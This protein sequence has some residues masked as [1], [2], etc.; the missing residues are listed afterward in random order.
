MLS[1]LASTQSSLKKSSSS[2]AIVQTDLLAEAAT[3]AI[4]DDIRQEMLAGA[5]GTAVPSTNQPMSVGRPWSM[6][7]GRVLS[8][9][10]NAT[11]TNF[12][13]LVKQSLS[14]KAFYPGL[15]AASNYTTKGSDVGASGRSRASAVNTAQASLNGRLISAAR[16]NKPMMLGGTGFT[17][18]NQL[19]D[20]VLISRNG[21]LT[22]G[23]ILGN[24]TNKTTS[25]TE[26]V[27]G[28]FA[29]NIYDVSGLLDINA[30]GYPNSS[31]S[32]SATK[33]SLAWAD[34]TVIPGM[35]NALA[36]DE[37][38][39]WRNNLTATGGTNY[40]R[41]VRSWAEPN[42][43]EKPYQQGSS[44]ENHFFSRQD[45]LHYVQTHGSGAIGTNALPY[46]TTFSAKLNQP[47]FAPALGRPKVKRASD[48]GGNDAYGADDSIN[49]NLAAYGEAVGSPVIKR[50]FPLDRLRYLTPDPDPQVADEIRK[51]FGL[52]WVPAQY[53]WKYDPTGGGTTSISKLGDLNREANFFELLKAAISVGSLGGQFENNNPQEMDRSPR[54]FGR[55]YGSINYQIMRIGAAIIDQYDSDSYPTR[56][57]FDGEEFYGVEDL[58]YLYVIRNAVYRTG[59]AAPSVPAPTPS[60][61]PSP[62]PV[63]LRYWDKRTVP[64]RCVM[65]MQPT[66]WNPH[67]T[68]ATTAS[69]GPTQFR[70]TADSKGGS[71]EVKASPAW[72]AGNGY[73]NDYP[74]SDPKDSDVSTVF[75]PDSDYINFNVVSTGKAS[76]REPYTLTSTDFPVGAD[77]QGSKAETVLAGEEVN[78]DGDGTE[79]PRTTVTG[80]RV[81]NLWGGPGITGDD[82][83]TPSP[84]AV[85][86]PANAWLQQ[87][88]VEMVEGVDFELKF[89]AP[90]N[91]Y[92]TYDKI[93]TFAGTIN[94]GW[95]DDILRPTGARGNPILRYGLRVDPR[96]DRFG[97]RDG[98]AY[99]P[100]TYVINN[101]V[102]IDT[103]TVYRHW[104][105]GW[106]AWRLYPNPGISGIYYGKAG[107]SMKTGHKNLSNWTMTSSNSSYYYWGFMAINNA[108][109]EIRYPDPDG[110]YRMA[111][112]GLVNTSNGVGLPPLPGAGGSRPVI[113]NRPFRSVAELGNVFRGDPWKQLNFWTPDSGDSALLDVFCIAEPED[114]EDAP[115]VSGRVNLNTT[116]PEIVKALLLGASKY[117]SDASSG[118][119]LSDSVA[120]QI[121]N[122][123]VRWTTSPTD[124]EGPLRS[125]SELVGK[126]YSGTNYLG[127]STKIG[128]ILGG[129]DKI[130]QIRRQNV[131][132]ALADTTD[133]RTWDFMVDLIVQSGKYPSNGSID[134]FSIEGESRYWVY[135]AI[136]RFSGRVVSK[137]VEAVNE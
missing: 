124:G 23:A 54:I 122:E 84:P 37:F 32:D 15:N 19:P 133:T 27:I 22:N 126:Y 70:V 95:H 40:A 117:P 34:I 45:L 106:T 120:Q 69:V 53:A 98:N 60:P 116:R 128:D 8:S 20:W 112:G 2:T 80:F 81:G 38:I 97:F 41:M 74:S 17:Q 114:D 30:A 71:V 92:Y 96:T 4:V 66:L 86:L 9:G 87:N 104:L 90:D 43:F 132:R 134:K 130:I 39:K 31:K 3:T 64:Y 79:T 118:A 105:H 46:L 115:V 88:R 61:M 136:D 13:N 125:R 24:Y 68:P 73:S 135:L 103:K 36:V 137:F 77:T 65:M 33:G 25:N 127:L 63:E 82:P 67:Q 6:I 75:D 49:V 50:R 52:V 28:R 101:G 94:P 119:V 51:Y 109:S 59:V 111:M 108:S 102:K 48:Q 29:Y 21:P 56:I 107:N 72:W 85:R 1:Y 7:P 100:K 76:F 93:D 62:A 83:Y 78:Q 55:A 12:V 47:S 10:I 57:I 91:N 110:N 113:L 42:G 35:T 123:V 11:D 131:L 129:D 26:Y 16:W 89:R 18:T 44:M 14:G 121:A 58:P 5:D 99:E